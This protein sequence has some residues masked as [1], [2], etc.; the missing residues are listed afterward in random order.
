MKAILRQFVR[1]M[2]AAAYAEAGEYET[3]RAI[4]EESN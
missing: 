2:E 4:S 3:A 1:T